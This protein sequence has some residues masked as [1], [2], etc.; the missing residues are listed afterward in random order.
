M[1]IIEKKVKSENLYQGKIIKVRRDLVTLPNQKEVY[2]EVVEHPGAVVILAINNDEVMFVEQYRYPLQKILLELPA[3]KID[4]NESPIN[5]AIRELQEETGAIAK[6]IIPLGKVYPSPGYCN[7]V[8]Y[9][10]YTNDF[11][12]ANSKLD[13]DEFLNVRKI[14]YHDALKMI[15]DGI[16][17]DAKTIIALYK[18]QNLLT[19]KRE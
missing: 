12:I 5:T 18:Y 11:T 9:L 8:I 13:D 7:E 2:R 19:N 1:D 16:I 4:A 6:E 10:Y 14:K 17:V 15:E 3:G